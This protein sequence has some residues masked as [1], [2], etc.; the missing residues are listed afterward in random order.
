MKKDMFALHRYVVR[1]YT[2]N[3]LS[4]DFWQIVEPGALFNGKYFGYNTSTNQ[5]ARGDW[6]NRNQL[7]V[8]MDAYDNPFNLYLNQSDVR[9][10]GFPMSTAGNIRKSNE[11]FDIQLVEV[12]NHWNQALS[13]FAITSTGIKT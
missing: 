12:Y 5:G 9:L 2:S 6:A 10:F 3:E 4:L 1:I 13:P 11:I 7:R 8:T